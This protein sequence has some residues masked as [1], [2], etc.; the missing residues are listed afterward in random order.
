MTSHQALRVPGAR[1]ERA[2]SPLRDVG[3]LRGVVVVSPLCCATWDEH[4]RRTRGF[5][6]FV[7]A[8]RPRAA[9]ASTRAGMHVLLS[10]VSRI[11]STAAGA[12]PTR[13]RVVRVAS[14]GHGKGARASPGID[15]TRH[16]PFGA[17][18]E[19]VTSRARYQAGHSREITEAPDLQRTICSGRAQRHGLES[20]VE[21]EASA[22]RRRREGADAY[23]CSRGGGGAV[24]IC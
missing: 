9:E 24:R 1:R 16:P 14:A 12:S 11:S 2:W 6:L 20:Y 3:V 17:A 15:V 23:R 10:E 22:A 7:S 19:G 4:P 21:V 13:R 8:H 18:I 5:A